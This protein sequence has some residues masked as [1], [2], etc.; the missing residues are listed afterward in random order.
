MKLVDFSRPFR[1]SLLGVCASA[2]LALGCSTSSTGSGAPAQVPWWTA[3]IPVPSSVQE[4]GDPDAGYQYL[5]HA[6]YFGCGLPS[7]FFAVAGPAATQPGTT[8]EPL[9]GRDVSVNGSPL[10]YMWNL[11]Q[12]SDGL[13]VV[14]QNC[15]TCH[16]GRFNGQL[17][18]GLGNADADFTQD[19]GQAS[20]AA[21]LLSLLNPTPQEQAELDKFLGRLKVIGPAAVMRTVGDNPAEMLATTFVSHRD[22]DTLAWSDTP[23]FTIP[24][25]VDAPA[26][27][28]IASKVPPWWRMSK[29]AAQFYNAMG[30]GDH[31][32]SEMLAGSLC[33]DTI[34]QANSI[35]AHFN[36]VNA[37]VRS[38]KPPTYPFA[39]D[40]QLSAQGH[41]VFLGACSG[42]HG[43]YAPDRVVYPN[44]LI[45]HETI[46]TDD[47]VSL[48]GTSQYYGAQEVDWYN[49]SWYGQ[50]GHYVPQNGYIAPPLDGVWATAPYLHNG[51]V[52]DVATLLDSSKRPKFWR[53]VDH[54]TTH[55]DQTALGFPWV[56]LSSGQ[57]S[58]PSRV[59]VKNIYDT[60][61]LSHSNTGH[62]FGDALSDDERRAVIEYLK[63]L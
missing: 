31:R 15:L 38:V 27:S 63:T 44:L 53:R 43:T 13:D 50:V 40:R 3:G 34:D 18:I 1:A 22:V 61:Q 2:A 21:G 45:P 16:A 7:R 58:P 30:R 62:I 12:N 55:Y 8:P 5:T 33:I 28:S 51:S 54:D 47:S 17:V 20:S 9:P 10:P 60:T 19:L 14:Y 59:A 6:G 24:A 37:F 36:D 11:A 35:D 39:I 42:C 23:F 49:R 26:G 56:T 46:L 32:R 41:E 52:P 25:V 29:K 57:N 48:G 4:A